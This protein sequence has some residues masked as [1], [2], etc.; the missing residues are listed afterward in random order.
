MPCETQY[1]DMKGKKKLAE[2]ATLSILLM[3]LADFG[4]YRQMSQLFS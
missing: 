2:K 1:A 3:Q 4:E